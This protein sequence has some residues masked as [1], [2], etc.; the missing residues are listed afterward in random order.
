LLPFRYSA[1][2]DS[3]D[4]R[5]LTPGALFMMCPVPFVGS[6][7]VGPPGFERKQVIHKPIKLTLN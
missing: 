4:G 1:C 3:I 7:T 2:N 5:T 6:V